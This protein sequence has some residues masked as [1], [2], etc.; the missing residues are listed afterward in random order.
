MVQ[1]LLALLQSFLIIGFGA[2]GGGLVTIPLI[3]HEIVNIRHWLAF[4]EVAR[5]LA[6]AQMTPGP[7]AINAA[8]F[9]GFRIA[10]CFGSIIA[11][12]AVILPSIF[13]LTLL[14]PALDKFIHNENV[15]KIR[16]GMQMGV[17]SLILFAAWSFGSSVIT[18]WKELMTAIIAF[19]FLLGFEG[20]LHPAIVIVSCGI[21]GIFIF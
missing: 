20:K 6:I 16:N 7:I 11:T 14:A 8:T 21:I 5:L 12:I 17:V 15:R 9:V 1:N 4:Y 2:C 3:Q 18:N 19:S 10:G 13:I